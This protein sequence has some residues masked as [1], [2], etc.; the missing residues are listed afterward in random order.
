MHFSYS[1][2]QA[3]ALSPLTVLLNPQFPVKV[4]TS[5]IVGIGESKPDL[6]IFAHAFLNPLDLPCQVMYHRNVPVL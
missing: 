6:V 2:H 3:F 4:R 1:A 5:F